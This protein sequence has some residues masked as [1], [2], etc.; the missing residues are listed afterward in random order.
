MAS[1]MQFSGG[2]L[3]GLLGGTQSAEASEAT[4]GTTT[5]AELTAHG[6]IAPVGPHA[7]P[8]PSADKTGSGG[9]DTNSGDGAHGATGARWL[10]ALNQALPT[11]RK[12]VV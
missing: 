9:G 5:L 3:R 7:H 1:D 6:V 12:S 4:P 11:D 10:F 8:V 2:W